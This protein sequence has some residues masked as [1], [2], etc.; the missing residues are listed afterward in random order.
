MEK[1]GVRR[2]I[3]TFERRNENVLNQTHT[4]EGNQEVTMRVI[5]DIYVMTI[6]WGKDPGTLETKGNMPWLQIASV[7]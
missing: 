5:T 1:E 6:L 4:F 3:S 2:Y 7:E